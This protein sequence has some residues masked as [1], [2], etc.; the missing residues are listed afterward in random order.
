M[1]QSGLAKGMPHRAR[2]EDDFLGKAIE[3]H[4]QEFGTWS[5]AAL[6]SHPRLATVQLLILGR[7]LQF[8]ALNV[9]TWK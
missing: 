5:Q 3:T 8:S 6:R 4:R 9:L 2:A 1:R 7:S